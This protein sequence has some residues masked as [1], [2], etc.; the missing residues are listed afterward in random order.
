[1]RLNGSSVKLSHASS[2]GQTY[3]KPS[4]RAVPSGIDL[5]EQVEDVCETV[6]GNAC[7][8][9]FDLYDRGSSFNADARY[10]LASC[11]RIFRCVEK[12]VGNRLHQPAH[13]TPDHDTLMGQMLLVGLRS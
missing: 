3:A 6:G 10:E 13:V 2:H 8:V 1:M 7:P 11:G 12:Q 4:F 9:V 5:G